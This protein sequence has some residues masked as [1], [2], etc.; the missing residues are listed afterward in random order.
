MYQDGEKLRFVALT[1]L[2]IQGY[3]LFPAEFY[4]VTTELLWRWIVPMFVV[5]GNKK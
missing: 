3:R 2:K 5:S 1:M 4:F